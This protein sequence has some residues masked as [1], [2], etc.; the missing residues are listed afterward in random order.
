M[1]Y[2]CDGDYIALTV[3]ELAKFAYP[4]ENPRVAGEKYGFVPYADA[5]TP[6][7]SEI[8]PSAS[9]VEAGIRYHN[10]AETDA[11]DA[12]ESAE[13]ELA[14]RAV[15]EDCTMEIHG[16]ADSIAFDGER[17]TVTEYK[18]VR[19]FSND[20]YPLKSPEHFAQAVC[21]AFM[22]CA[23]EGIGEAAIALVYIR[24]S[25]GMR[26]AYRAVFDLE[27]LSRAFYALLERALPFVKR[28][29]DRESFLRRECRAMP[30]PFSTMREGQAEFI[31]EGYRTIRRG[32]RLFVSAPT[33]IGKTISSLYPAI[34][35]FG[36]G[37]CDRIFYATA[38]TITGKAAVDTCERFREFAPHLRGIL[39]LA[40]ESLCSA[41]TID[42]ETALLLKCP[43]C[44]DLHDIG[45]GAHFQPY[46][47][48]EHDAMRA[49][50]ESGTPFFTPEYLRKVAAQYSVCPYELSLDISAYCEVIVCDYNF[51]FDDRIR[52]R[53]YFKDVT[54][55]ERYVFCVDEAHNL[56]DR[57]RDM[58]SGTLS[59]ETIGALREIQ[60]KLFPL[61]T[62]FADAIGQAEELFR[63]LTA[64]CD[65][66]SSLVHRD[67]QDV[68]IGYYRST[69]IPGEIGTALGVVLRQIRQYIRDDH[70]L[71]GELLPYRRALMDFLS[72]L[73]YADERFCFLVSREDNRVTAQILCLDPAGILDRMLSAA[74]A[75]ILFSA[76][77]SPAEYYL[78]VTGSP[79]STY[80]ELPSPYTRENLCLIAFDGI[81]TRFTDRR[82]TVEETAEILARSASVRAGKYIAYFP[83][84][85]YMKLVC[86]AFCQI[87]P[88]IAVVMQK[89]GMSYRERERFL[90]VFFSEKH[91]H[92][93]G[94]CVLG[95]MFSEGI[96]L[97][98]NAL[99]GAMIV[100]T[101]L[102]GLS[103]ER[104]LMAE[105][106]QNTMEK[107]R[108][109]AY[110]FPGMNKVLQAA[111]RVIR[112]ENDR[113]MVLLI[114]DRYDL[115]EMKLLF[116][117]HWHHIR[118]TRDPDTLERILTD[119]WDK[120]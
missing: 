79:D 14:Y 107:G 10:A 42:G 97:S 106:Y 63:Y 13:K 32:E 46:L 114:D 77:L 39:I 17:H 112:S 85:A 36:S 71:V 94:F 15:L 48:R 51:L 3:T 23:T 7:A 35:A 99:I 101:G 64:L 87:A 19:S 34:R 29:R 76:T 115:P 74:R 6:D 45:S 111:G 11:R 67:G 95:G 56:P 50:L 41:Q 82:A 83:S 100:G 43:I 52:F 92:V 8:P 65:E 73:D 27:F 68:Q 66:D 53:R 91:R 30:F 104:N 9:P 120:A 12:G 22:I 117:T 2:R 70:E 81:S 37:D 16:R 119:F 84:Y 60:K 102:P 89:S 40:K 26:R 4:L 59:N 116:P 69:T 90:Q 105:Y 86:R 78:H 72:V 93:M 44:P 28:I 108:E 31:K 21:Y 118:Y 113:G 103:P 33:G 5:E 110:V 47:R 88:E 109:Y 55:R 58:Y 49:L 57:T 75:S 61:D 80:L 98:G 96:D 54:R 20:L 1:E 25:D 38:K 24:R 62:P 18:T